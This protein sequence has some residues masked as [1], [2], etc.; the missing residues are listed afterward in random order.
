MFESIQ[1]PLNEFSQHIE[2]YNKQEKA[3]LERKKS[4]KSFDV[5]SSI[6]QLED[7]PMIKEW[8]GEDNLKFKLLYRIKT[9]VCSFNLL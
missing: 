4:K 6:I 3:K 1:Q 9:W 2:M 8:I 7:V 5:L